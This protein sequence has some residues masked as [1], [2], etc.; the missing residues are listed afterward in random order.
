MLVA[1]LWIPASLLAGSFQAV[2][3]SL[4]VGLRSTL[5]ING[6]G[7]I[8]YAFG[9]PFALVMVI[10]WLWLSHAQLP[11][12]SLVFLA[13]AAAGGLA[14]IL[15][16][17]MLIAA[18]HQ[19]GFVV[20]T[21]FSKLEAL[22]AAVTSAALLKERL[23]LLA[24]AGI[25]VGVA[26][27]LLISLAGKRL[28]RTDLRAVLNDRGAALGIGAASSFALT[29]VLVKQASQAAGIA[30]GLGAALVTLAV[31]LVLQTAMQGGWVVLRE[32][33][34][35]R[36]IWTARRQSALVGL[37]SA[38]GSACWFIGFTLAPVALVRLL[39]QV[40]LLFTVAL[41]HFHLREPL[42]RAEIG[43]LFLIAGGSL[44]AL[45]A[46]RPG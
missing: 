45:L 22:I 24:W 44:A 39:G 27:I 10:A 43:G 18:S 19:R 9:A 30:D 25:V 6:A 14:Q 13:Y 37:L 31:V 35:L 3:S 15:G 8:R 46:V 32:P 29:G 1:E 12:P 16:T 42:R 11:A 34:T 33:A 5:S 26:G 21:A 36:H 23:P 2:R 41:S 4:Q 40:E 38:A 17:Q 7:L 20:G 28:S